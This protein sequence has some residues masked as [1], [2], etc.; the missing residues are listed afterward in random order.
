MPKYSY[1]NGR[2]LPHGQAMVHVEDRGFLFSDGVYEAINLVD[3]ELKL[4]EK[5]FA[6]LHNSLNILQINPPMAETAIKQIIS[7]LMRR[8]K[9]RNGFIY[10]Q[11][12]RGSAPRNHAFP[13]KSTKP[14]LVIILYNDKRPAKEIYEVGINAI[15]VPDIRWG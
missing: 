9:T 11:V 10:L 5:H 6:R 8:N 14:S 7:E 3:G 2:Y 1:I 13:K 12:T 4:G 15:T